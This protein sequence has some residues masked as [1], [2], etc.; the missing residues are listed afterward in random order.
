MAGRRI[1]GYLPLLFVFLPVGVLAAIGLFPLVYSVWM[2]LHWWPMVPYRPAYFLGAENYV[3]LLT[4]SYFPK[5]L[6]T[7]ALYVGGSVGIA[8]LI[9]LGLAL[10]TQAETRIVN[11]LRA[12]FLLP[13]LLAPVAV[14]LIFR[15]LYN[16]MYGPI[17]LII[18]QMTGN[19]VNFLNVRYAL[20]SVIAA[21]VWQWTPFMFLVLLSAMLYIPKEQYEASE[22]DGVN[23]FQKFRYITFPWLKN[24]ILILVLLRGT[25]CF[26]EVDKIWVLTMGGPGRATETLAFTAYVQGFS[27]SRMLGEST[28]IGLFTLIIV[29]VFYI[30]LARVLKE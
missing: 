21:D 1:G 12:Y 26:G 6:L 16:S 14:A 23:P 15:F 19:T 13:I 28:A 18:Q 25:V 30:V 10:L 5:V 3:K 17:V 20:L 27:W 8:F 29:N 7:T 2:S 9:G 24:I 4:S 22:V 11:I